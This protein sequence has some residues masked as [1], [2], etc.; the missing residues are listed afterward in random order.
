MY[1]C[2]GSQYSSLPEDYDLA[3][4]LTKSGVLVYTKKG[5]KT[6]L[7]FD[8]YSQAYVDYSNFYKRW[9]GHDYRTLAEN[10]E[11]MIHMLSHIALI[12]AMIKNVNDQLEFAD[13]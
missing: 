13:R 2:K 4:K 5:I 12:E 8:G 6:A 10:G 7:S 9:G 1:Y 3:I 11:L